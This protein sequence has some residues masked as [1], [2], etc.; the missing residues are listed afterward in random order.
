MNL[1]GKTLLICEEAL[2]E[3][4]GHFYSWIKA[5]RTIHERAGARVIVA[6]NR[7]MLPSI[8]EEFTA[9]PAFKVNSWSGLYHYPQA[10]KRYLGVFRHNFR[11]YRELAK[12][13]RENG[14]VDCILLPAVR[15]HHLMALRALCVFKGSYFRRMVP[16]MLTSEAVY[17]ADFTDFHFKKSSL[18][19]ERV[20]RSF[21][22]LVQS[23]KV[24]FAG[25]SH[26][27][28]G[29]YER[30][31]GVPFQ[32][33]PSP[34]AGLS[35]VGDGGDDSQV[36][37]RDCP[38]FTI[39]GVSVIDK[40]MDVL[41]DAILKLLKAEPALKARFVIQWSVPTIGY[42]GNP[43]PIQDALRKAPQV[44]LFENTLS[45]EEYKT[46]LSGADFMLLPYRRQV[47][48]NRLSGVVVEAACAG[49]P[50]I[51]TENTWLDWALRE[52]GAGVTAKDGDAD[53][54]AEKILFCIENADRLTSEARNKKPAALEKNSTENY[55]SL[56]WH[57]GTATKTE[58]SP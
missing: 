20:L 39:L 8:A 31:S 46:A 6:G 12:V 15:I 40:G 25:D 55:L 2:C 13:L 52:Y 14:P 37:E 56:V 42:D 9:I 43:I 23:G 44:T 57:G 41:Q 33:F 51:V 17:N 34:S 5:I 45:E 47:Y 28:C 32:V 4:G 36:R 3:Y 29:E 30:M 49:I 18:L 50:M 48:F 26:V 58:T 35:A 24:V 27:T 22:G 54:L 19:S 10:W 53:D 1:H 11:L 16:F 21:S 38:C 7:S